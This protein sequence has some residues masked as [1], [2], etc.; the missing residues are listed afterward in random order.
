M[1][2]LEY[3]KIIKRKNKINKNYLFFL[4]EDL[5]GM[6][7]VP[8]TSLNLC[9]CH[10]SCIINNTE[11]MTINHLE[12]TSPNKVGNRTTTKIISPK[13]VLPTLQLHFIF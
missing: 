11:A 8:F 5:A 4:L 3:K 2:Y 12:I 10:N 1:E 13:I 7:S 9:L 6:L